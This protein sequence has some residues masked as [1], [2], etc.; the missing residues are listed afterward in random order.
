MKV[1]KRSHASKNYNS[2]Y[3]YVKLYFALLASVKVQIEPTGFRSCICLCC[4]VFRI[5][6]VYA[7]QPLES[8]VVPL[9]GQ[10]HRPESNTAL[11]T[12]RKELFKWRTI[13]RVKLN[14]SFSDTSKANRLL[15]TVL[16]ERLNLC[17][18]KEKNQSSSLLS[19]FVFDQN[20]ASVPS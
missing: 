15:I 20:V 12:A 18:R 17:S 2:R 9:S 1:A 10:K 4:S 6:R 14:V 13:G 16:I 7:I 5:A 11:I 3:H 19:S 8:P